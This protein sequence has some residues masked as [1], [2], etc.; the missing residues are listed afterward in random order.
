MA[1]RT[2]K[3]YIYINGV[4]QETMKG[5]KLDGLGGNTR[6]VVKGSQIY[7]YSEEA[8]EVTLACGFAHGPDIS[9]AAIN[10]ITDAV[11]MFETDTGVIFTLI[12]AFNTKVGIDVDGH[13]LDCEFKA[14][15]SVETGASASTIP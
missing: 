3:A 13:K 5:A 11:I 7:G 15:S 2:G 6:D 1:A 12:D 10:A 8:V 9:A 14:V 4:L